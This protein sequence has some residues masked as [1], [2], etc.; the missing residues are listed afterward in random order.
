MFNTCFKKNGRVRK[1]IENLFTIFVIMPLPKP[2]I[3]LQILSIVPPPQTKILVAA[4]S[5]AGH[6]PPPLGTL[7]PGGGAGYWGVKIILLHLHLFYFI[8]INF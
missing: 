5:G 2:K 7:L 1:K 8:F 4:L 3:F 6:T